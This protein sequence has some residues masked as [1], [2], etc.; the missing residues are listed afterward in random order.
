LGIEEMKDEID[1]F[2]VDF[3]PEASYRGRSVHSSRKGDDPF[4]V[5]DD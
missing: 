2:L 1:A 4:G 3:N 5:H